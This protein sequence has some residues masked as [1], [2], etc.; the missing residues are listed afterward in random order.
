MILTIF[1]VLVSM[2]AVAS[3]WVTSLIWLMSGAKV[4]NLWEAFTIGVRWPA[5]IWGKWI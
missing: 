3:L 5:F 4:K 2:Y 1:T